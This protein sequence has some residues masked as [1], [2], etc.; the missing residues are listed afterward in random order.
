M[1]K[2]IAILLCT[3]ML[4]ST[5]ACIVKVE[6]T[7]SP[8]IEEQP[9]T[10]VQPEADAQPETEPVTGKVGG[11][12][13]ADDT[14][15][16]D[17]LR[18][19]FEKA[20]EEL[21]GVN[22]VPVAC[23]G[24]QVVAGTNYCFLTQGTVVYPDAVP[25]FK[26]VYVY[27]DLEG[28]AQLLNIVDMP[29]V[30]NEDGTVSVPSTEALM[31]GWTYE[32]DPAVSDEL[33]AELD[34]ALE[35]LAGADYLPIA[36]LA[37][38]VVNGMNRCILCKV[39]PVVPNPVSHYA[40]VYCYVSADGNESLT[41]AIDFDLDMPEEGLITDAIDGQADAEADTETGTDEENYPD[42]LAG[43][44]AAAEDPAMTDE[45]R[46]IFDKALDGLVGVDY[47]PIACLGTQIVAGRN[48]CFLTKATVVYPDAKPK[49]TLIYVYADLSGNATIMNFAD[50]PVIPNE[51]DGIEPITEEETLDGGWV[52]AESPEI[53][54]EI[55]ANLEKAIAAL[56]GADYEPVANIA[57]QVVAGTN[58]C[59]LC[60]ITPVVPNPVPHYALVYLYEAL[61]GTVELLETVDFDFGA[62][63]TYGA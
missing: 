44:W 31:G 33:K 39:T 61:D 37:S 38:Q 62:L 59:L 52:Y 29:V 49:Y 11:W 57:T 25:Q 40:L 43:G 20:L 63:C 47:E 42:V 1:K 7:E 10:N 48:Y 15:M 4:T 35:G 21:V 32:S 54:D 5:V 56:V 23:L 46:A 58:R 30:P 45:L 53:T 60:K 9:E 24:T 3:L 36:N 50:M 26:L 13:I 51:F 12:T 28:N 18:A 34:K 55:K 14:A 41:S 17:E 2:L 22:Y 8:E 16:T 27:A 6:T 19:I